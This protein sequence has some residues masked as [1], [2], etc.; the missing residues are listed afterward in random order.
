VEQGLSFP[1]AL[2]FSGSYLPGNVRAVLQAGLV[3]GDAKRVVSAAFDALGENALKVQTQLNYAFVLLMIVTPASLLLLPFW[4]IAI[5]P[6]M[7]A[8]W[9]SM[10]A[11][12]A[13]MGS[14]SIAMPA[15]TLFLTN[16]A[17]IITFAYFAAIAVLFAA[18]LLYLV[19]PVLGTPRFGFWRRITDSALLW[20]PWLEL[21]CFRTFSIMLGTFLDSGLKEEE[22]MRLA[23]ASTNNISFE[24][25]I[26]PAL[27]S[28]AEGRAL[29]KALE[30]IE[31][32][33]EFSWRLSNALRSRS[34]F[35]Q[36]LSGWHETL[37]ARATRAEEVMAHACTTAFV[38]LNGV[39]I[40]TIVVSVFLLF[41]TLLNEAVLW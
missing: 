13:T 39:L 35:L 34:G 38:L 41:V 31:P 19:N 32:T 33:G 3:Y 15:L 22:A 37:E 4:R 5:W 26:K 36:A 14:T 24:R 30:S 20:L 25:R 10:V 27:N 17:F 7:A 23:A 8:I 29:D 1:K 6:K 21:R 40:G 11:E 2:L 18:I 28:L 16:N 12:D 9:D